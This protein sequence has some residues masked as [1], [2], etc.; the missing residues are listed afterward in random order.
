MHN[1]AIAMYCTRISSGRMCMYRAP[2][3]TA[4]EANWGGG[5]IISFLC[6]FATL[7]CAAVEDVRYGTEQ[8]AT[9]LCEKVHA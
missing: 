9:H 3:E 1:A 2:D 8:G 6:F 5:V 7:D 4:L